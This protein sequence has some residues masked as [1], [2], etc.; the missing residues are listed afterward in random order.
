MNSRRILAGIVALVTM[1][2]ADLV[3]AGRIWFDGSKDDGNAPPGKLL[4]DNP[5]YWGDGVLTGVDYTYET[6]PGSPADG[7]DGNVRGLLDG[8]P[9]VAAGL[10]AGKP[11]VVVFDFKRSCTWSEWDVV[12][13]TRK[14]AITLDVRETTEG[15]WTTAFRREVEAA[16]DR[17]LQRLELPARPAGR[18]ARLTL[19]SPAA[20]QLNEV[21]A[22][23]DSAVEEKENFSP[24]AQ[25]QY[26]V[27]VA[28]P[29]VTGIS[30]SA[31][32]DRECS[33]WVQSLPP[34]LR[35]QHAV[36]APVP[37]WAAISNRP[38]LPP[39]DGLNQPLRI[40][41]AQN[42]TE[43]VAL[44]LKNTLVDSPRPV[45]VSLGSFVAA[46]GAAVP[47]LAV[48]LG[49]FGTLGDRAFGNNLGPIFAADN[50]LGKSLL[51]RY[52]LNGEEIGDFPRLTLAPSG[53]VILWLTVT[54]RGTAP[55][56]YRGSLQATGVDP[57]AVEVE[58]LDVTLPLSPALVGTYSAN[59]TAMFPFEYSDRTARDYA[60]ALDS[61]IS[62]W[63]YSDLVRDLARERGM[64]V[65]YNL[66]LLIPFWSDPDTDYVGMIWQ[67]RWGKESDLPADAAERVAGK[68]RRVVEKAKALGLS[69]DEW[70][71]STGDEPGEKNIGA[72]A[73]MCRLIKQADPKVNVYV[74]PCYWT[75]WD[76]N[77]GVADDAT[78]SRGLRGETEAA[79]GWYRKYVD[80]SMP[81]ALLLRD[82]PEALQ[83]LAAPRRV[84]SFYMV[85]GHLGRS[86]EAS[87]VELYRR[88]AWDSF[89]LGFNGWSF[90]AWYSP[91]ANPWNHFDRDGREPSDYQIVYPGPRGVIPTRQS[92]ALREGWEDWRLLN[93]LRD[94]HLDAAL[95]EALRGYRAGR[96]LAELR[97][98]A[99]RA[100]AA[101]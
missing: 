101:D 74:N 49:V 91:R 10:P 98:Q 56:L 71:G 76:S 58:V 55:G 23:G 40:V 51:R 61:G 66:G 38:V 13:A 46:D 31:A 92:E 67:G 11:L 84:N 59:R 50:L 62:E 80:I 3:Q 7:T 20:V 14:V 35:Q 52:L 42:E 44:A 6:L 8:S 64:K 37:T 60:Y 79:V 57:L 75:G 78:L 93:L 19:E 77:G 87:E 5:G 32:S 36:W 82:R 21:L 48:T 81:L 70:F 100:A 95:Q 22:W 88:M 18:Y 29:T 30:K 1:L 39:A 2:T 90:Y 17:E 85:S 28:Y 15:P 89:A 27:G 63:E 16:P 73:A 24:V 12:T 33:N 72:V 99:L 68:V 47:G 86:E 43:A 25:G 4:S 83:E 69:Y 94:Q 65:M 54:T 9:A 45:A 96:P 53:A 41:L 26:P 34:E 97:L